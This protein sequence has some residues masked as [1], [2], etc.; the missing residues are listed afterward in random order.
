[1][2]EGKIHNSHKYRGVS[3]IIGVHGKISTHVMFMGFSWPGWASV[4]QV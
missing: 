1:M 4:I 3:I 2:Y